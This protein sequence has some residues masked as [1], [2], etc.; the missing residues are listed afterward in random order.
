MTKLLNST[1][2]PQNAFASLSLRL[3]RWIGIALAI[4]LFAFLLYVVY[5]YSTTHS[6][7]VAKGFN[8]STAHFLATSVALIAAAIPAHALVR[9]LT[10]RGRAVDVAVA[11]VLPAIAWG[12]AQLPGNFVD[13][14][15]VKYC[16][17][18][19]GGEQFCLDHPGNDPITNRPLVAITPEM[20]EASLRREQNLAATP[21]TG[22]PE[23]AVYFD[24]YNPNTAV[25]F[26]SRR[27][28]GCLDAWKNGGP[29]PQTGELLTPATKEL[30]KEYISCFRAQQARKEELRA[31]QEAELRTEAEKQRVRTEQELELARVQSETE[32]LR[33]LAEREL[34]RRSENI[35]SESIIVSNTVESVRPI[36]NP[37]SSRYIGN[38][39]CMYES[40]G[41]VVPGY[42]RSCDSH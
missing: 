12:I 2:I 11:M 15:A 23:N 9:I 18:R 22:N 20:A 5:H 28:D 29:H 8:S 14:K 1:H 25:L 38:D 13:G 41:S 34:L 30:V 36:V 3:V 7:L 42:K 21:F 19:P 33:L 16:S 37:N 26:F 35:H 17:S 27:E 39:G 24:K 6:A 4:Y 10:L 31:K 40:N 32:R